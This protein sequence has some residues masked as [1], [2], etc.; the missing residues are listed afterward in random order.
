MKHTALAVL[1]L[2]TPV[3]ASDIES[4]A[5]LDGCQRQ[6]SLAIGTISPEGSIEWDA[7]Q[8]ELVPESGRE[9]A[10]EYV[11]LRRQIRELEQ[12]AA[13]ALTRTCATY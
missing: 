12:Q 13:Q 11:A 8:A 1:L 10:R 6:L 2:A 7:E 5:N 3:A 4:I 9:A